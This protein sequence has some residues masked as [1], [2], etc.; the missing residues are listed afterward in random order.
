MT[1]LIALKFGRALLNHAGNEKYPTRSV[2]YLLAWVILSW[3]FRVLLP[4]DMM[5]G[6]AFKYMLALM[7]EG[8]W[9]VV[10]VVIGVSRLYALARNG[11]WKRSPMLRFIG[12]AFGVNWWL[13]LFVLYTAA[14]FGGAPD[15]PMRWSFAVFVFFELYSCFRCGQDITTMKLSSASR[16]ESAGNG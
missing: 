10:G 1:R 8:V 9:G 5:A 14:V 16:S 12:A 7:P 3:S 13:A 2:E 11:H 6:P 15:F 4:G